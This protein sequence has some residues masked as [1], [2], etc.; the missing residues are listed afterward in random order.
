MARAVSIHDGDRLTLGDYVLEARIV[1]SQPEAQRTTVADNDDPFGIGDMM[2][3]RAPSPASPAPPPARM[4]G[5]AP[6]PGQPPRAA[7]FASPSPAVPSASD[8]GRVGQPSLIPE[9]ISWL[10]ESPSEERVT[11]GP[12]TADS[13]L[14]SSDHL[15]GHHAAFVPPR[16]EGAGIPEDWLDDVPSAHP[17]APSTPLRPAPPA[18]SPRAAMSPNGDLVA[19]F[20]SGAELPPDALTTQDAAV[21]LRAAGRAYRAAVLGLAEILRARALIKSEFH[22]EKTR[23]GAVGNS[24]LK[25]LE[26]ADEIMAAMVGAATPGFQEAGMALRDGIRDL[27]AHQLAMVAATQVALA[28]LLAQ[29]DPEMLKSRL[30]KR[31][32]LDAVR[33]GARKARYWEVFEESYKSIAAELEEDFNGV[34]GK[35]FA[36]AYEE[37]LRRP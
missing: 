9:G 14:A 12:L 23:I 28:R 19:A 20:L 25:F 10:N 34:F 18:G 27:K 32:L 11:P 30:E 3:Q 5:F 15:A 33:P 16:V 24:P 2:V 31:S 1:D 35:A 37:E 6:F 13:G 17:V 7:P 21:V 22:I 4:A 36:E 29:L 8:A 26:N